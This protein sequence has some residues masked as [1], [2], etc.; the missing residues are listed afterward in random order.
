MTGMSES[1][2]VSCASMSVSVSTYLYKEDFLLRVVCS[3]FTS[4]CSLARLS[5][6]F[7]CLLPAARR[8]Y[9]VVPQLDEQPELSKCPIRYSAM[10]EGR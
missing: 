9:G 10:Q 6:A 7:A 1:T 4:W 5:W 3:S 8:Y 2:H